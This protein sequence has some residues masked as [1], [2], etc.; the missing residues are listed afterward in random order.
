MTFY[1]LEN[2]VGAT[3]VFVLDVEDWI[4]EV[5][6]LEGTKSI[7]KAYSS[8]H[9]AVVKGGLALEIN[10]GGPPAGNAVFELG[11]ERMKVVALALRPEKRE[12]LNLQIARLLQIM[13]V[14]N[15]VRALLTSG[16]RGNQQQNGK[17]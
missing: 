14:G 1:F 8:E 7:L 3:D 12:I 2:F 17:Q 6:M 4:D 13:V 5:L 10:L 16:R 9:G 15:D 11:P